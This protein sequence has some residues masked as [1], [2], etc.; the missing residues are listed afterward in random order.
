[1]SLG[2]RAGAIADFRAAIARAGGRPEPS[3]NLAETY[4]LTGDLA[5]ARQ[6]IAPFVGAGSRDAASLLL[7]GRIAGKDRQ[8]RRGGEPA[9]Q[10]RRARAARTGAAS[11]CWSRRCMR[12]KNSAAALAVRA[13]DRAGDPE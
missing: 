8:Q 2:D 13:G 4:M 3:R 7:A 10:R 11:A 6:A 9:A 12:D 1:M 5:Q